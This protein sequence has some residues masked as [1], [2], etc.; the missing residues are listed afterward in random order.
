M[1]HLHKIEITKQ[2]NISQNDKKKKKKK[3]KM[4]R[5]SKKL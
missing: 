3:K 1:T 2:I 4:K 5:E